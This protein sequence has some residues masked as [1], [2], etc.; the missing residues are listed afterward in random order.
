MHPGPCG[1]T[2]TSVRN[3]SLEKIILASQTVKGW[4]EGR[5]GRPVFSVVKERVQ[6]SDTN[7]FFPSWNPTNGMSYV[8]M[9]TQ[10]GEIAW[11][12]G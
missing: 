2:V 4:S 11:L 10:A 12:V 5:E 7:S 9:T 6:C 8:F 3:K 1:W